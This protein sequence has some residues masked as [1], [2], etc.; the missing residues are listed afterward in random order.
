MRY[1]IIKYQKKN[2]IAVINIPGASVWYNE[3]HRFS[4]EISRLC[5]EIS[6]DSGVLVT[7]LTGADNSSFSIGRDIYDSAVQTDGAAVADSIAELSTPVI[8]AVSGNAA[9]QGLE[10][11]LACDIRIASEASS[12][13]MP[14]IK[15]G[16]MPQDGGT[17]RLPRLVGRSKAIEMILTGDSVDVLEAKKIGLVSRILPDDE[18]QREVMDLAEKIAS[19][20][21]VAL[22]YV[23]EAVNKGMD[24]TLS[25]GLQLEADLYYLLHTTEDRVEGVKAFTEKRAAVFK[26]K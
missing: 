19:K 16:K 22:K 21:P 12:F 17:Q 3:I 15:E 11:I 6:L 13:S 14:C 2:R 20:G 10:M 5:A 25:Q 18:L 7:V 26:G 23:K 24:M 1:D 4:N 8:A 9:G